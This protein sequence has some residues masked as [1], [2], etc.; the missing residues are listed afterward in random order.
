M[1]WYS[2]ENEL[3][4]RLLSVYFAMTKSGDRLVVALSG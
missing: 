3:H 2:E 4:K 1:V